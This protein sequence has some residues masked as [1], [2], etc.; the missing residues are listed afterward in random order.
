MLK[1]SMQG[2]K[3]KDRWVKREGRPTDEAVITGRLIDR[4]IRPLFPKSFKREVGCL[5]P[6]FC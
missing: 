1:S 2:V 4:T 6:S 5:Y 3:L